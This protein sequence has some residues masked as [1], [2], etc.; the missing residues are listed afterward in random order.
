[1]LRFLPWKYI[2][3][4]AARAYGFADPALWLARVRQFSQPS[5]VQEPIELLRA[6][7]LFHARG[8]VNAKAIQHNLD[9]VW[10][11]WV[12]RQFDPEDISFIP[13][14]FSLSHINLTHRNWTAVGLPEL[15]VYPIVD[16]RGLVTPLHDGWSIDFWLMGADGTSLLPSRLHDDAFAQKLAFDPGLAVLS[17]ARQG[18]LKL[19]QSASVVIRDGRPTL[20]IDVRGV[21]TVGGSLVM[22]IRPYNPE[23]VQFIDHL[24]AREGGDG[25]CVNSRTEVIADRAADRLLVSDYESGDVFARFAGARAKLQAEASD[26]SMSVHCKVGMATG[27]SVYR[28]EGPRVELLVRVPLEKELTAMGNPQRFD[29]RVTWPQA[30]ECIAEMRVPDERMQYLYDSAVR[31]LVLLSADEIVPGPYT[32]RRFWFRDACLMMNALLAIGLA[33]RCRRGIERFAERQLRNGYF[34]SQEGEWDSNGQVLWIVDRYEALSGKPLESLRDSLVTA[35][36]WIDGKRVRDPGDRLHDGLLPA[37]FS[38]EHLGPNDHYYW[39]DFWTEAGLKAAERIF[40]RAGN[41]AEADKARR[42][43]DEMR[44]AIE[45]SIERIPAGRSLGGIPASP[46]RR[47]DAGAVGSLVADYPLQ[48]FAPGAPR[49]MATVEAILRNC[50]HKG[51]FFQDII[52]SGINAYLTLDVAQTLLRAGDAR[53]RDLIESVALLASPTGQWPEA[54]HPHTLGGCMGDGQHGWAAAEWVMMM[55]NCFVR[56]EVPPLLPPRSREGEGKL[57][58]GSGLFSEWFDTDDELLFGPTL[59]AWGPVTVRISLPRSEPTLVIEGQWHGEAPRVDV[60]IPRF[61]RMENVDVSA[62]IVFKQSAEDFAD[63]LTAPGS[64]GS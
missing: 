39:D 33:E 36:E 47:M 40:T 13:R 25:W 57:I 51:G 59:T 11:Y 46:Y 56:E 8:I 55:R 24:K 42:L 30:C 31:T 44:R 22:A 58:I 12:E 60:V 28:F 27:A 45:R 37:G 35:V 34:R 32:Y 61:G 53:Y 20:E 29:P 54:I 19:E 63:S 14:A 41:K 43:A 16:P 15:A 3:Q 49:I 26:N 6:G 48:L 52:H 64:A 38:A 2:V 62:S 5:D 10:P 18:E 23:G 4:R 17:T 50:F 7:V 9:W 21:S 1:M